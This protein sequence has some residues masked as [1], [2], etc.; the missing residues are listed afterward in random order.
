MESGPD[1][2]VNLWGKQQTRLR[3]NT[4]SN[5]SGQTFSF[6]QAAGLVP[7]DMEAT[8]YLQGSI[9]VELIDHKN[10]KKVWHG[11]GVGN[12]EDKHTNAINMIKAIQK[13]FKRYPFR[14]M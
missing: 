1:L 7:S 5:A 2:Y 11:I 9:W 3:V 12:V 4:Y 8:S 6:D 10:G 14:K 13:M